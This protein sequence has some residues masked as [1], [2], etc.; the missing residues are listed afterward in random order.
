MRMCETLASTARW[1]PRSTGPSVRRL[2]HTHR[3][4]E[5]GLMHAHCRPCTHAPRARMAQRLSPSLASEPPPASESARRRAYAPPTR[6]RHGEY[7]STTK[8]HNAGGSLLGSVTGAKLGGNGCMQLYGT[9][10]HGSHYMRQLQNLRVPCTWLSWAQC[11]TQ[12]RGTH[13]VGW[14]QRRWLPR[15]QPWQAQH[16]GNGGDVS[17]R[18]LNTRHHHSTANGSSQPYYHGQH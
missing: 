10:Q 12:Q 17:A 18:Q 3:P 15:R 16:A 14:V 11:G 2:T 9:Y 13:S 1:L 6:Q 8:R 7:P 5:Y 4:S